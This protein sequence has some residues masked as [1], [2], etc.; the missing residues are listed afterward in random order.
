[1]G[2]LM[3]GLGICIGLGVIMI[4]KQEATQLETSNS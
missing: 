4:R 2:A 3:A 1:V